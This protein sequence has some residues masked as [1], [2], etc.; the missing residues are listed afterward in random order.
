M[1]LV[2]DNKEFNTIKEFIS[3]SVGVVAET[4][5][6]VEGVEVHD[7][8]VIEAVEGDSLD[9]LCYARNGYP[10]A[11]IEWSVPEDDNIT[12]LSVSQVRLTSEKHSITHHFCFP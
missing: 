10:G 11:E 4:G 6:T 1:C 12:S 7:G 8:D 5:V 3:V 9:I 2:N